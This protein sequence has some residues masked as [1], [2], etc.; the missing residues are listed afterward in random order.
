[1]PGDPSSNGQAAGGEFKQ[2]RTLTAQAC[3]CGRVVHVYS[4]L[5]DGAR[6]ATILS[7]TGP[8]VDC[9]VE[10]HA[11]RDVAALRKLS[12][13]SPFIT[14]CSVP[15]YDHGTTGETTTQEAKGAKVWAEWPRQIPPPVPKMNVSPV[16]PP[17]AEH[18]VPTAEQPPQAVQVPP[19][20]APPA[21]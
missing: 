7:S 19:A 16:A 6:P 9:N 8:L 17:Q 3:A 15:V 11:A 5:W 2:V 13:P 1:M 4:D 18:P 10:L 20:D 14:L 21:S 12:G